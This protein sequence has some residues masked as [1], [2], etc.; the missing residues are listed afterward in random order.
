MFIPN[1]NSENIFVFD[2]VADFAE[3]VRRFVRGVNVFWKSG[4]TYDMMTSYVGGA[5]VGAKYTVDENGASET[6][7][8][9]GGESSPFYYVRFDINYET[10]PPTVICNRTFN[11]IA[12]AYENGAYIMAYKHE[13]PLLA[14]PTFGNN[15]EITRFEFFSTSALL[16]DGTIHTLVVDC[17]RYTADG[18]VMDYGEIAP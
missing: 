3:A 17:I 9:G 7:G 6:P 2:N 15:D 14:V 12:T 11:E 1:P 13:G 18:I 10:E 5:L 8:G 16:S 4:T